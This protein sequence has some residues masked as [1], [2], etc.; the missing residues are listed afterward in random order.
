MNF[1]CG[2]MMYDLYKKLTAGTVR[3]ACAFCLSFLL[4]L[5]I[6]CLSPAWLSAVC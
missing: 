2:Q 5:I 1:K 4:V 3:I 6:E